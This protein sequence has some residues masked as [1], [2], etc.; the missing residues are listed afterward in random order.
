MDT[1]V[2]DVPP[3]DTVTPVTTSLLTEK[4]DGPAEIEMSILSVSKDVVPVVPVVCPKVSPTLS[5]PKAWPSD[6]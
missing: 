2:T 6:G 3:G 5:L 4:N 1:L